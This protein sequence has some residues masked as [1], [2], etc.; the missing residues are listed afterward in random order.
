[1]TSALSG[2]FGKPPDTPAVTPPPTQ[3]T[4]KQTESTRDEVLRRLAKIRRAT[5]T[6]ELSSPNVK[7]KMM[8]AGV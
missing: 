6:S 3:I 4:G 8:G 7:R 1:M 2:L 5:V